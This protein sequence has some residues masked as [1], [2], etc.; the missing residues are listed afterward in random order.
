MGSPFIFLKDFIQMNLN[1]HFERLSLF[2]HCDCFNVKN[3][4]ILAAGQRKLGLVRHKL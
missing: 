3:N 2:Y 4:K 1:F